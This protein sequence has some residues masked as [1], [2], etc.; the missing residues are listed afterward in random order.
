[1]QSNQDTS[2]V[3]THEFS[4]NLFWDI[5]P[6]QLDFNQHKTYVIRRVLDAGT[7]DDWRQVCRLFS[8][9]VIID[10][11]TNLR[12]LDKKSLAFLCAIANLKPA[13]FRCYTST[14]STTKHW[15]Y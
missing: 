5:D 10:T 11:A 3:H 8:L 15:V 9:K 14:P 2:S 12:A 1:M 7:W 6:T 13:D 4:E